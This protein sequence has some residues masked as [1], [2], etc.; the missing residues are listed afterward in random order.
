MQLERIAITLR[1]RSTLEA[2]DLGIAMVARWARPVY[3]LWLVLF[4]PY[5]VA[6]IAATW[7]LPWLGMLL[8][9]WSKPLFDRFVLYALSRRVFGAETGW[10]ATLRAWRDIVSPEAIADLTWRR[11]DPR[12]AFVL[13]VTVLERQ[14][15]A[16]ARARRRVLG[17]RGLGS[18]LLLIVVCFSFEIGLLGAIEFL[19]HVLLVPGGD[20]MFAEIYDG[21][22]GGEGALWTPLAVALYALAVGLIEPF[23]VGAGFGLY[24]NR[25]VELEAWDIEQSLRALATER[26]AREGRDLAARS[27]R[28]PPSTALPSLV[29]AL[30]VALVMATA[31][32]GESRAS[33][34]GIDAVASEDAG[35]DIADD[36][37]YDTT[38]PAE[39]SY[40]HALPPRVVPPPIASDA[41]RA[42]ETVYADPL[43]GREI[44]DVSWRFRFAPRQREA[45]VEPPRFEFDELF[46]LLADAWQVIM[47]IALGLL[48]IAIARVLLKRTGSDV[49]MPRVRPPDVVFGLDVRRESLPDDPASAARAL[50]AAGNARAAL[51][52]IYRATLSWLLNERALALQ[53][54]D[55]EGIVASKARP[56]IDDAAFAW[57]ARLLAAWIAVAYGRHEPDG[58]PLGALIDGFAD[59]VGARGGPELPEAALT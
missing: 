10:R 20:P 8:I 55:T 59:H 25:R 1:P 6:V 37:A 38:N 9:W 50:L 47:W 41:R 32:V 26:V 7:T 2:L 48:L 49:R 15:G 16:A 27:H 46:E 17:T 22:N 29:G 39:K 5:A 51:A 43:F 12:R 45:E 18:A 57:F 33:D 42:V 58:G 24:L 13:P 56:L 54:G 35:D 4:V 53:P 31:P 36:S 14:H 52:L 19:V 34:D 30:V 44:S 28:S 23:Y 3:A 11:L 21:T 40:D